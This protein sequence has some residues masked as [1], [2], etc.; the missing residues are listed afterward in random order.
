MKKWTL[1]TLTVVALAFVLTLP[2]FSKQGD[3]EAQRQEARKHTEWVAKSLKEMQTVKVGMTRA[4]LLKVFEEEGGISTR[5][6]QT[7]VYRGC[8]Y[9]KVD[10]TFEPVGDAK[11]GHKYPGDKIVKLS[12]PYL[13]WAHAD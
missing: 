3:K 4:D 2:A 5:T 1:I 11:S 13:D 8:L 9:F 7:Y 10:V 12:Q 6:Q